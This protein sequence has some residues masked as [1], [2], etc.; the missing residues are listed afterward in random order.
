MRLRQVA[1]PV[2]AAACAAAAALNLDRCSLRAGIEAA[3]AS[4]ALGILVVVARAGT[5]RAALAG[6]TCALAI[7]A[8]PNGILHSALPCLLAVM[9]LTTLATRAGRERKPQHEAGGR[10]AAQVFSN[11]SVAVIASALPAPW[12]PMAAVAALAECAADTLASEI[13][14]LFPDRVWNITG[15][16]VSPGSDG[17]V[18]LPGT[19]AGICGAAVVAA[20]AMPTLGLG[21]NLAVAA[22]ACGVLGCFVDSLLGATLERPGR[23]RNNA[24][25]WL[26]TLAAGLAAVAFVAYSSS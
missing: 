8:A 3:A 4:L 15:G 17:G 6:T 5:W 25:N 26:S 14:V 20:V 2:L 13:G 24:V 21:V 12:G 9:L 22:A 10:D 18:T 16:W 7:S 23:L 19:L 1:I 11:L